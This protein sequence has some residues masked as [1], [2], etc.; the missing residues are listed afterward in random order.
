MLLAKSTTHSLIFI[1]AEE[2]FMLF[3]YRDAK[4]EGSLPT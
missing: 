3:P 1:V 4:A 2:G